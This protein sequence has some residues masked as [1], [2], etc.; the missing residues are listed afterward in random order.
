MGDGLAA[1]GRQR[2]RRRQFAVRQVGRV[3]AAHPHLFDGGGIAPPQAHVVARIR[4]LDGQRSAP[5]AGAKNADLHRRHAQKC[6]PRKTPRS[7]RGVV[8]RRASM[9]S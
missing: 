8:T 6:P 1:V 2:Q 3:A 7:G 4:G 9:F 5:G